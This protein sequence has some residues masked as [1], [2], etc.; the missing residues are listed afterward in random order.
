MGPFISIVVPVYGVEQYIES[1][2]K[3]ICS[4]TFKDFEVVIVNDGTKDNSVEIAESI[5]KDS[6]IKYLIYN[7]ENKGLS[8]ARNAGIRYSNGIWIVCVDP[9]DIIFKDFL[10]IL[11]KPCSKYESEVSIG[12]F[13]YVNYKT[14]Y[15]IP[16]RIYESQLINREEMTGYFLTRKI[17]IIVPSILIK[18]DFIIR[19]NLFFDE[20]IR[21]SEDQQFIWRLIFSADKY[22]YNKTPIYNYF[23]RPDSIMTSSGIER[24]MTG[25]DGFVKLTDELKDKTDAELCDT[26]VARWVFGVLH[27]SAKMM[28]YVEFKELA[29]RIRYRENIDKLYKFTDV[30]MKIL[31]IALKLN[32]RLFYLIIKK[33]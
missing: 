30:K 32:F 25:Y 13:Q 7:Q 20:N 4:Q 22:V 17:K 31:L 24:I 23:L 8:A 21:F 14:L 2:M 1:C 27:S 3:S 16:G 26:I 29:Q 11:Y 9:D 19:N 6:N 18:K 5:L 33:F 10:R 28:N 15:K 12:N